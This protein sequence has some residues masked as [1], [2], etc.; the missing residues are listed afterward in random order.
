M[1]ISAK[2]R[3]QA[4]MICAI[5]ASTWHNERSQGLYDGI[6]CIRG[7][8]REEGWEHREIESDPAFELAGAALCS[9]EGYEDN[10]PAQAAEAE[11]KL[12]CGWSPSC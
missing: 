10:W 6:F 2:V 4:A 3:E 9:V 5:G 8:S 12:R 1:K 11:S 7:L